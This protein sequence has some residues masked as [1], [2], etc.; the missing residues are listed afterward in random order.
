MSDIAR[1]LALI[2]QR[3]FM[4]TAQLCETL[5]ISESTAR[6]I[7]A[8]LA[9]QGSVQRVHGGASALEKEDNF[10]GM[11]SRKNLHLLEKRKIAQCASEIIREGSTLI[12]LGGT[13]VAE[14][15]PFIQNMQLTVITNS[16]LVFNTLQH[17][18]TIR[19]IFLGGLFNPREYEVG[20][21]LAN[22][23]LRYIRADYL[24]M[25]AAAF[26]EKSGFITASP[27]I[28][29]YL[30]CIEISNTICVL[31]DSSKYLSSG[32]GV[33]AKPNEVNYLF[34]DSGLPISARRHFENSG[35]TVVLAD[36]DTKKT[37]V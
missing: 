17:S 4:S 26:D 25:G 35:V 27:A 34:T 7:M 28:E 8:K 37:T 21:L 24:F 10:P 15:C 14:L 6:R 20:G 5:S 11:N 3:K 32:V 2:N 31:A 29:L 23:G 13:N 18:S 16:F 19:L 33:T 12:L 22:Q 9:A 30:S 36:M 1:A